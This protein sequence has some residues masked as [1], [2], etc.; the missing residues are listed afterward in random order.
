[1]ETRRE[2]IS[3]VTKGSCALMVGGSVLSLS[4]CSSTAYIL[5]V[6]SDEKE[7]T[8]PITAFDKGNFRLIKRKGAENIIIVKESENDYNAYLMKCTHKG[9][10]LKAR[11]DKIQCPLHG[12]QFDFKGNVLRG[13]A[14]ASLRSF[15]TKI[16][17]DKLLIIT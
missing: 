8:V 3:Q 10:A 16:E 2:F 5:T 11:E 9:F 6:D 1:M 15:E 14:K 13:P 4:S 12:S 17:G 7:I